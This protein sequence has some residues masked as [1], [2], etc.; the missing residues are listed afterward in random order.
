ML[1]AILYLALCFSGHDAGQHELIVHHLLSTPREC[2]AEIRLHQYNHPQDN[3]SC[4][5]V[6]VQQIDV[7]PSASPPSDA[8]SEHGE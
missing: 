8:D 6:P 5:C 1:S 3:R 2:G 4:A 7:T